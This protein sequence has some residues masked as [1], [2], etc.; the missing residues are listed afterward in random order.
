ME[1]MRA[2]RV[3]S[4]GG[5]ETMSME[6]VPKPRPGA[7]EVLVRVEA[8]AVNPVDWKLREGLFKDLPL[9]F[10]PG[11]DFCG[12]VEQVGEGV[13]AFSKGDPVYGVAPGSMGAEAEFVV[14]PESH[15][16]LKPRTLGP[17]EAA[18][19]PLV[20]MTAWQ[21]LFT[22]GGLK[23]GQTVLIVGASGGVGTVAVQLAK[24]AGA[25]VLGTC[26]PD[27]IERLSLLGCDRPIDY[28]RVKLRNAARDVDL[29]LDLVGGE[30]QAEGAACLKRGGR[31]ISAVEP[32]D[33]ALARQRGL[34][35]AEF[36]VMKPDAGQLKELAT[37]IE[38]GELKIEV[39]K[40]MPLE[41]AAEAE[42]LNRH[43]H[44]RGKIVLE[45]RPS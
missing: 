41:R 44:V 8:T 15:L 13:S 5:P 36:F 42:E 32:P 39:A 4:F 38:A 12:S 21:G 40:V 18:S 37:K 3:A 23:A 6:K 30:M 9:P 14:V 34:A 28:T 10:T 19:V 45:V 1:T 27:G 35:Q 29:C 26:T 22:H 7:G 17:I 20:G 16:S 25:R 33:E 2:V 31:L 11:G 43:H 24:L